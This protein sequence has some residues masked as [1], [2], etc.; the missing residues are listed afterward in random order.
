MLSVL[1]L[2]SER[3]LRESFEKGFPGVECGYSAKFLPSKERLELEMSDRFPDVLAVE[4]DIFFKTPQDFVPGG[5]SA[6]RLPYPVLVL[7]AVGDYESARKCTELGVM[8]FLER[9]PG[10]LSQWPLAFDSAL[11]THHLSGENTHFETALRISEDRFRNFTENL[12]EWF[13]ILTQEGNVTYAS[14]NVFLEAGFDQDEVLQKSFTG[15]LHKSEAEEFLRMLKS[16]S[17]AD[18]IP[19]TFQHRMRESDGSYHWRQTRFVKLAPSGGRARGVFGISTNIE[20]VRRN[21]IERNRLLSAMEQAHDA[22]MITDTDGVIEYA[23][24]AFESIS[25]YSREE[26][27]GRKPTFLQSGEHDKSHYEDLWKTIRAGKV[28]TGRFINR[29]KNGSLFREEAVISPVWDDRGEIVNYLCLKRDMTQETQLEQQLRQSQKMEALGTL[30]GGIAHDFNNILSCI[31]GYTE[32]ASHHLPDEHL[33][34]NDL[35]EVL[36]AGMRAKEL[37]AQILSFSRQKP[38]E[39]AQVVELSPIVKEVLK[40]LRASLPAN[41]EVSQDIQTTNPVLIAPSQFHQIVMNL[42]T[43]AYHA[44]RPK[45]GRLSVSLEELTLRELEKPSLPAGAYVRLEVSDT[46]IGMSPEV[47]RRVFDPFFTT[48][49][50][51]QG[52]GMGLSVVHGIVKAYKG[53]IEVRSTMGSGSV[54]T[55]YFPASSRPSDTG[56][57][58]EPREIPR[59]EGQVL[60]VDD[61]YSLVKMAEDMLPELGYGVTVK[62]NPMAALAMFIAHPERYNA[63][64]TDFSMPRMSG[65]E[66]A[67][68]LR[69]IRSDLP[70]LI[71]TAQSE[72]LEHFDT[73]DYQILYKPFSRKELAEALAVT[74]GLMCPEAG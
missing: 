36:G 17:R 4:A 74:L 42:C 49:A 71:V 40:L 10:R 20:E 41:I 12:G 30:A 37:V 13:F 67:K 1:I 46:G 43:N 64:V 63:L 53:H 38:E 55:L 35:K 5:S 28:W 47:M 25:G 11:R 8:G 2:E 54:F 7:V 68:Q 62:A 51:G 45:D 59:G 39:D 15:L 65:L 16:V 34:Q 24:T 70:V 29:A 14:P 61:E 52:T 48:K 72:M 22:I 69:M 23:N 27:L 19:S 6:S 18:G 58:K 21:R 3:T 32:L 56:Q 26:V 60:F 44:M 57:E 33:V 50:P 73:K 66:L 31:L 9:D